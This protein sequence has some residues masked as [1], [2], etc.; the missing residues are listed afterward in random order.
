MTDF[1]FSGVFV[2]S[3]QV[4][5]G[6]EYY[7]SEQTK[8]K[9]LNRYGDQ[10][11][12]VETFIE[13][14]HFPFAIIRPTKVLGKKNKGIFSSWIKNLNLR[15]KIDAA[16]NMWIAPLDV[17]DVAEYAM[18]LAAKR[19]TGTW[20]LSPSTQISYFEAANLLCRQLGFD[21][22]L[23]NAVELTQNDVHENLRRP[24][25]CLNCSKIKRFHD[26]NQPS[27]FSS[28]TSIIQKHFVGN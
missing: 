16:V 1:G 8:P 10:K 27:A 14:Q 4:Y 23:V 18:L 6:E 22:R 9:P 28:F 11:L 17:D 19:E 24:N 2:S 5:D 26:Y 25:V 15:Q 7:P 21:Q 3:S 12:K 13:S 20:N